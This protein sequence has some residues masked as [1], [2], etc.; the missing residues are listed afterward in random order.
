MIMVVAAVAALQGLAI[1]LYLRV[2][3]GKRV[4]AATF[5]IEI[6]DAAPTADLELARADGSTI[7]LTALKGRPVLVHFWATWCPP[8]RQE[9]PAILRVSRSLKN[10]LG[11]E[12]VAASLDE[13]WDAI[14]LF[15]DGRPPDEVV[16]LAGQGHR[17]WGIGQLPDSYLIGRDGAVCARISGARDWSSPAA[18]D[19]LRRA[20][21]RPKGRTSA[22]AESR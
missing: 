6:M 19:A 13:R 4:P 16:K 20:L 2:E 18:H 14:G 7:R 12:L 17:A 9:M 3:R 8:C 10:E 21:A 5:A 11:L 1:A 15:F 22:Q